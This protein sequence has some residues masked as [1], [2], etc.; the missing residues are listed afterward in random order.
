MSI[1]TQGK[2]GNLDTQ[3]NS[4]SKSVFVRIDSKG[5]IS[6][7][8]KPFLSKEKST[9]YP[10]ER[11]YT[12]PV[13]L[14]SKGRISIPSFLRKNF[15]LNQSSEIQ[16]IFDLSKNFFIVQ[17]GVA[18]SISGCGSLGLGSTPDSGP[19]KREDI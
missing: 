2:T 5:R 12:I 14:D 16:L 11:V 13:K 9:V 8:S 18:D 19:A 17:N 15:G 4:F 6:I 3:K 1:F 10:K 7:P